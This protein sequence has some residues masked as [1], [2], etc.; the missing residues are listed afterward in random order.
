[1]PV[2]I[3]KLRGNFIGKTHF[4]YMAVPILVPESQYTSYETFIE[5]RIWC[6]NSFGPSCDY[7]EY[8]H[9]SVNKNFELNLKWAWL[10]GTDYRA[11]R[12]LLSEDAKN[13]FLM[14]W[15]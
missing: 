4:D 10:Q 12:I 9:A 15:N 11:S 5:M 13:W 7:S 14:R 2:K 3:K 8:Q 6:W 1:M